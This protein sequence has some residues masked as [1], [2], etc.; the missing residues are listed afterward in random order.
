MSKIEQKISKRQLLK[1]AIR[2]IT[3]HDESHDES[4]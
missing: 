1:K 2:A 3:V 4:G